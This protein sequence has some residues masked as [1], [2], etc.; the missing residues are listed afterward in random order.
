MKES[1]TFDDV[2]LVP[3]KSGVFSRKDVSTKTRLTKN[4]ELSI[5][6]IPANMDTVT[7]SMMARFIAQ[8]GGIGFIHR[9]CSLEYQVEQVRRVKRSEGVIIE[10]PY[11][12]APHETIGEARRLMSEYGVSGLLVVNEQN[13]LVGIITRRDIALERDEQLVQNAMTQNVIT[14][15]HVTNL[16]RAK[17]ILKKHRIEKLPLV[18]GENKLR[19]LITLK[20]I[21]KTIQNG[22]ATK[23]KKGRLMVGAAI[24]V[25]ENFLERADALLKAGADALLV[26]VAHGHS[27]RVIDAVRKLRQKFESVAIIAGNV[28]TP[29]GVKDL[30]KAGADAIKVG[31][32]P[33]AGCITRVVTGV[34]VPQLS[35][36]LECAKEAH[37]FNVPI[38]ADGGVR[39]SGDMAKALAAGAATVMIG[40]LFAG[41]DEAPG[42]YIIEDGV[43]YKLYR[44]QASRDAQNDMRKY[45]GS[46]GFVRAPEG[47]A[48]KVFYRGSAKNVVDELI[49][50]LRS[51]M[52]YLGAHTLQEFWKNAEFVRMTQAGLRE[53]YHHD[54]RT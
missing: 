7:E 52:S 33:G 46:D 53:S 12:A 16:E 4:I 50:G 8:A 1:L 49:A 38:I 54:I 43:A 11:T 18:D 34:G 30:I 42:E 31:I 13:I 19:G 48:G 27:A 14:A 2:L 41:T 21:L 6:I 28:A 40:S 47:K 45:N 37:R 17:E 35:A 15:P 10:D 44:G 5:P 23:D 25:R 9:F 20:D 24:G 22:Y 32:G 26:D 39:T 36:I 29:Q 3:K 51:S